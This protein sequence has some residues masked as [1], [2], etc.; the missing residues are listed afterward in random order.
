MKSFL[1][2]STLLIGGAAFAQ[3]TSPTDPGQSS[4]TGTTM[5]QD[6]TQRDPATQNSPTTTQ[7]PAAQTGTTMSSDP[8]GATGTMT[9]QT[10]AAQGTTG[11]QQGMS[12]AQQGMSGAQQGNMGTTGAGT[13][14]APAMAGNMA[15][16][17]EPRA[18][19][20]RCSRTVTDNCVQDE[21]RAR[22]TRR[23]R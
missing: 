4:T 15:P 7:D 16:P 22:D 20:P 1:L 11:A 14:S 21:S 17:P 2:A 3:T 10:G 5:E 12:G 18:S 13:M 6:A 9:D 23:R 8:T 19:Y